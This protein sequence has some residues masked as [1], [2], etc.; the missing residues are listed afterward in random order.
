MGLYNSIFQ[1][2]TTAMKAKEAGRVQALR[3][4][5]ASLLNTMKETG[6]DMLTDEQT[7]SVLQREAKKRRE[8]EEAFM[9]GGRPELA[10]QEAAER[11]IIEHYLPAQLSDEEIQ[12]MV[13]TVVEENGNSNFGTVMGMVMQQ[14]KGRADGKRV[15]AAVEAVLKNNT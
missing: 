6:A 1:D 3:L 11:A 5:K 14:V 8:S 15:K 10:A 9:L 4:L 2:L 13:N 12:A 7:L